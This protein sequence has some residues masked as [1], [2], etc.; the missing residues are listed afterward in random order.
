MAQL[1]RIKTGVTNVQ[2]LK[3]MVRRP[4]NISGFV[5]ARQF[6]TIMES[7]ESYSKKCAREEEVFFE[8]ILLNLN[9]IY[10][11]ER[12]VDLCDLFFKRCDYLMRKIEN[13]LENECILPNQMEL[14]RYFRSLDLNTRSTT[15][16]ASSHLNYEKR[17]ENA[18]EERLRQ[19]RLMQGINDEDDGSIDESIKFK[20]GNKILSERQFRKLIRYLL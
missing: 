16:S 13:Y 7:F 4:E 3:D 12:F 17:I 2:A 1:R 20:I 10:P 15:F 9:N 6:Q 8:T 19:K 14:L 11:D 18:R 5:N